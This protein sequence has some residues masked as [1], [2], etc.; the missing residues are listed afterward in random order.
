MG[1]PPPGAAMLA[2]GPRCPGA[3][4]L[5]RARRIATTPLR[6]TTP[7]PPCGEPDEPTSLS[8]A[9]TMMMSVITTVFAVCSGLQNHRVSLEMALHV[10]ADA[11]RSCT[12]AVALFRRHA[13]RVIRTSRSCEYKPSVLPN[14]HGVLSWARFEARIMVHA[15]VDSGGHGAGRRNYMSR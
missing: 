10:G 2:S 11:S 6:P 4:A 8:L 12:R 1:T 14:S 9:P 13:W 7:S 3:V 5:R 15:R